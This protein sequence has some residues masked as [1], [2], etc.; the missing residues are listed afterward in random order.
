MT[1]PLT[2]D[3]KDRVE[4]K[5]EG[6][7]LQSMPVVTAAALASLTHVINQASVSGKRVG[8]VVTIVTGGV[9]HMYQASG[10]QPASTWV[11]VADPTTVITPV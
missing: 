4:V 11:A 10:S 9:P 3:I 7:T 8:A 2:G 1:T 6:V 5:K